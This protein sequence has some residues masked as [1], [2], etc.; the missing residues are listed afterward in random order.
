MR[1][2]ICV[3]RHLWTVNVFKTFP[4]YPNIYIYIYKKSI[5]T[6][7]RQPVKAFKKTYTYITLAART[8]LTFI[9]MSRKAIRT[10]SE[11]S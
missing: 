10:F 9:S 8:A 3:N 1:S 5:A 6:S 2:K 11:L 7:H 4:L